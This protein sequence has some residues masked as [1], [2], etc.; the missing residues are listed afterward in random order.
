MRRTILVSIVSFLIAS[1]SAWGQQSKTAFERVY[2]STD[3][4]AYVAG[5]RIWCSAFCFDLSDG[6]MSDNSSVAYVEVVYDNSILQTA[7]IALEGGRGNGYLDLPES[8][9]TGNYR[10]VGFTSL[11][12]NENGYDFL[13]NS[14]VISVFNPF[15]VAKLKDGVDIL[16]T[17]EYKKLE[18]NHAFSTGHVKVDLPSSA[19]KGEKINLSLE[20]TSSSAVSFSVSVYHDDGIIPSE[21]SDITKIS[22]PS[23]SSL[24]YTHNYAPDYEG[25]IIRGKITGQDVAKIIA[26]GDATAYISTPGAINDTYTSVID[27]EGKVAFKTYNIFGNKDLVCE[28]AD[29]EDPSLQG[30]VELDSPFVNVDKINAPVLHLSEAMASAIVSRGRSMQMFKKNYVDSLSS[31]TGRKEQFPY[32]VP[33]AKV[34]N[35]DDYTRFPTMKEL[36]VEITQE[37]RVRGRGDNQRIQV[38]THGIQGDFNI[39]EWHTS[40]V[41]LDG[42]PVFKHSDMMNYDAM[43]LQ[44][45]Q[46][47]PG[48]YLFANRKYSGVVNF[49]SKTKN[50]AFMEFGSNV[51]IVEYQGM[52]YP[53]EYTDKNNNTG[54]S[55]IRKT[56]LWKPEIELEKGQSV[57]IDCLIPEYSGKFDIV[58]EGV[59]SEGE[60]VYRWTTFFA[61]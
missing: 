23:S 24:S 17:E 37:V 9:P 18:N 27:E 55:D 8:L 2:I 56:I 35:L 33:E 59:T 36:L 21:I 12:K 46:V 50:S 60:P 14:K 11:N 48:N 42:V 10:L 44:A 26:Q 28:I 57:T 20:N 45:V 5:D 43:F 41:L 31:F 34:Y 61:R 16:S 30:V 7:K 54:E 22:R 58:I 39:A 29:L 19:Q 1:V 13:E 51:R 15:S 52:S 25:E 53:M 40:L 38:L 32:I 4:A 49:V 47:W 6:K 3:K